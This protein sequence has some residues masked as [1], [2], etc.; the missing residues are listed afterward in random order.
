MNMLQYSYFFKCHHIPLAVL[1]KFW[2][3]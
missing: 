1:P 2:F 3:N